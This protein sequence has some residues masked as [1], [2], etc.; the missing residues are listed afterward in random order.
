MDRSAGDP[1]R[2][3]KRLVIS[4]MQ[5]LRDADCFLKDLDGLVFKGFGR[6]VFQKGLDGLVFKG[7]GLLFLWF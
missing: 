4:K 6:T 3:H 2:L 7:F 1:F 5:F